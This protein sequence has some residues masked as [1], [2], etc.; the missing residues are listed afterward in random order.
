MTVEEHEIISES[1]NTYEEEQKD[2]AGE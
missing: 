2:S 1:S